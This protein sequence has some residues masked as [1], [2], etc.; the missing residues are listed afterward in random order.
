[1]VRATLARRGVRW[2]RAKTWIT[3]PDPAY[4]HKQRAVIG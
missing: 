1:M 3:R 4:A 2:R